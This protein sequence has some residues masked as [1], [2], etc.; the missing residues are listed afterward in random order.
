AELSGALAAAGMAHGT[1]A[2]Q[3]LGMQVSVCSARTLKGLEVDAALVVEPARIAAGSAAGMRLLYVALSRATQRL[4]VIAG[5]PL[6][7]PLEE[8]ATAVGG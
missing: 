2:R 7:R 5:E 6:P 8:A 1:S 3:A 4:T